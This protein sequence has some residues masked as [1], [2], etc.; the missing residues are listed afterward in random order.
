MA[1]I[2]L[3][4]QALLH[5][6]DR[7]CCTVLTN[8]ALVLEIKRFRTRS[9]SCIKICWRQYV[10]TGIWKCIKEKNSIGPFPCFLMQLH[11]QVIALKTHQLHFNRSAVAWLTF[12][13]SI[14][15]FKRKESETMDWAKLTQALHVHV[16]SY[17]SITIQFC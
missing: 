12:Q 15:P 13:Y 6:L 11:I 14:V 17:R 3:H 1:R 7:F 5:V 2:Y 8:G 10:M 16:R 4:F 9:N